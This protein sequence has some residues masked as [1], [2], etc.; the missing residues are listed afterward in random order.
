MARGW[1]S[2]AVEAQQEEAGRPTRPADRPMTAEEREER[3]RRAVIE[4][5]RRKALA[6][7]R[8]A[9]SPVHRAMLTAAIADLDARLRSRGSG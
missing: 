9:T 7:L 3:R 8:R 5:A 2:K 6:D 1:E 4:L